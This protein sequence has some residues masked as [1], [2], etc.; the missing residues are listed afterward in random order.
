MKS[1]KYTCIENEYKSK[2]LLEI[3][4]SKEHGKFVIYKFWNQIGN[5]VYSMSYADFMLKHKIKKETK[6]KGK[7]K[8]GKKIDLYLDRTNG[9]SEVYV[10]ENENPKYKNYLTITTL[11]TII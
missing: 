11:A 9:T 8:C 3:L 10:Y 2:I 6:I 1:K 4:E 7:C 5:K